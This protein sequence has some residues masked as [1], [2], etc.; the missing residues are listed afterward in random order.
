QRGGIWPSTGRTLAISGAVNGRLWGSFTGRRHT[1]LLVVEPLIDRPEDRYRETD[2]AVAKIL[3]SASARRP[4]VVP[5]LV[6]AL[7]AD[8]HMAETILGGATDIL[9][10]HKN[11]AGEML[12]AAA[13]TN[14]HA[15]LALI[16]AGLDL[17]PALE[18]AR[19]RVEQAMTPRTYEPGRIIYY[20][21]ANKTAILASVLD[22]KTR[23]MF[24]RTMFDRAMDRREASA[25]RRDSL[26][27]LMN[28]ISDADSETQAALLPTLLEMCR[29]D[30]DGSSIDDIDRG[31]G[32]FDM[33][34][35]DMGPLTLSDLALE[36]AAHI[37]ADEDSCVTIE[38]AAL[39]LIRTTGE[40]GQW[41][42]G[43][44]LTLL[45]STRSEAYLFQLASHPYPALRAVAAQHWARDP[46]SLSARMATQLA[47]DADYRVRQVLARTLS[48]NYR[49]ET[50]DE[51]TEQV[52]RILASDA[53]RSVRTHTATLVPDRTD[54]ARA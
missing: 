42:I 49:P 4:D 36:C 46:R 52:I 34:R 8:Q 35:I 24:A 37:A 22:S 19:D 44:V 38:Q 23:N 9:K 54:A 41:R 47:S 43:R 13:P 14:E 48:E 15:C 53:R 21:G 50:V 39:A 12:A 32:P 45:P 18:L 28:I 11:V 1:L 29:G 26:R 20:A 40:P 5:L 17:A 51:S 6:R 27:G 30:H 10:A 3:I 33:A 7:L 16:L 2:D 25:S 31:G